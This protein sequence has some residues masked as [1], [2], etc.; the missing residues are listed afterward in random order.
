[1]TRA[2]I[3]STVPSSE[4]PSALASSCAAASSPALRVV[5]AAMRPRISSTVPSVDRPSALASTCA[6]ASATWASRLVS[7]S[8]RA[9]SLSASSSLVGGTGG[10]TTSSSAGGSGVVGSPAGGVDGP[11]LVG[12]LGRLVGPASASPSLLILRTNILPRRMSA[13]G[14]AIPISIH[15][16]NIHKLPNR[17][18]FSTLS[19]VSCI[20]APS[21]LACL[22]SISVLTCSSVSPNRAFSFAK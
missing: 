19:V 3:S 15:F 20:V 2:R 4:R 21:A 9:L 14:R 18:F 6:A 11:P 7:S 22:P 13:R 17:I 5:S 12:G 10:I 8:M 16:T 1:M